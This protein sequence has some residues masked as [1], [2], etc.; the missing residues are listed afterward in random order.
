MLT[1]S[2]FQFVQAFTSASIAIALYPVLRRHA[3]GMALGSVG[4]RLI[5]GVF[6]AV[7][8]V[9]TLVLV[10]LVDPT[11]VS[12][13]VD[14]SARVTGDLVR[15]L[16]EAAAVAGVLAFYVGGTLYYLVLYRAGLIPRWISAWGLVG[17][18][19]GMAA[20]LLV[21][22]RVV[23]TL[24]GAQ[25]ALNVPIGLQEMVFAGWLIA[26]GMKSEFV[27]SERVNASFLE[28]PL[29]GGASG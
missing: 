5:E 12:A 6:Y 1:A 2:F 25:V 7:S 15:D 23:D 14:A 4:F 18:A 9:G 16:R 3:E 29:G 10:A 26:K 24:S 20:A 17:T 28:T 11:I 27:A 19:L 21:L 8:A 22:F 13:T